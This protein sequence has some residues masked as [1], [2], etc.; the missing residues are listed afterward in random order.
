MK[1]TNKQIND[2]FNS[3]KKC[4]SNFTKA[5]NHTDILF[6]TSL[7]MVRV[8]SEALKAI[9][10]KVERENIDINDEELE[11]REQ[12]NSTLALLNTTLSENLPNIEEFNNNYTGILKILSEGDHDD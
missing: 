2:V 5:T 12:I 6:E 7:D 10:S 8:T 11:I 9:R 3:L 1:Y 4:D